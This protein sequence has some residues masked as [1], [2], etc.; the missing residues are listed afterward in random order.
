MQLVAVLNSS[1]AE[2]SRVVTMKFR[3]YL[4]RNRQEERSGRQH[5]L[6]LLIYRLFSQ[7]WWRRIV[8]NWKFNNK[9]RS[10]SLPPQFPNLQKKWCQL[11]KKRANW[12]KKRSY[13]VCIEWRGFW[14]YSSAVDIWV[15]L[16]APVQSVWAHRKPVTLSALWRWP[17]FR[18][19]Y[20]VWLQISDQKKKL[21]Q[22]CLTTQTLKVFLWRKTPPAT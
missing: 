5:P 20:T 15:A 21:Q 18:L 11:G 7:Q 12:W 22:T 2:T 1:Q 3:S 8:M 19:T 4:K 16:A 13:Q 17:H 10:C 9:A 6:L 14:T